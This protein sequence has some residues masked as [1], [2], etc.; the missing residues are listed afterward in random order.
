MK[1]SS[2]LVV[3]I[4]CL[5]QVV[6]AI[7]V[8]QEKCCVPP[9]GQVVLME[10]SDRYGALCENH[11]S[12]SNLC[13]ALFWLQIQYD[14]IHFSVMY[15]WQV[16]ASWYWPYFIAG[17]KQCL[18]YSSMVTSGASAAF[19]FMILPK[20][21]EVTCSQRSMIHSPDSSLALYGRLPD[22]LKAFL[23]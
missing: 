20:E 19:L 6:S 17:V 12:P 21:E 22:S 14:S 10:I 7:P 2:Y 15:A 16:V 1:L 11:F 3:I 23:T 13:G 4:L 8:L 5:L 9:F 18:P